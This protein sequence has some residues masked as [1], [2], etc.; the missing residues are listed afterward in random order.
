MAEFTRLYC[1]ENGGGGDNDGGDTLHGGD[2]LNGGD[3]LEG[4]DRLDDGTNVDD[5]DTR[6]SR[7][8]SPHCAA[9][10][11]GYFNHYDTAN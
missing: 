10:A 5:G 3:N 7:V 11:R 2:S 8:R 1:Y 4:G 6:P 9:A